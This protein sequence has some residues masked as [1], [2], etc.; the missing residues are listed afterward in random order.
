MRD[1]IMEAR[2]A[3]FADII[4]GHF[5]LVERDHSWVESL[6]EY[7]DPE[8]QTAFEVYNAALDSLCVALPTPPDP[9]SGGGD[10][11][12]GRTGAI[13]ECREAIHAAGIKTK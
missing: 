2:R 3:K 6:S 7:A 5:W 8:I 13:N 11:D 10:F 12:Y 9:R 4:C 1:K